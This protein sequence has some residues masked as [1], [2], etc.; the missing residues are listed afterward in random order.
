MVLFHTLKDKVSRILNKVQDTVLPETAEPLLLEPKDAI[1]DH[2]VLVWEE[3]TINSRL[4]NHLA[5]HWFFHSI[6][7]E[8]EENNMVYLGMIT[9]FGGV[10]S[11][12]FKLEDIWCDDYRAAFQIKLDIS[13]I[14]TDSFILNTLIHSLCSWVLSFLGTFFNPFRIGTK[15]S[16]MRFEKKGRIYFDMAPDSDIFS[17]VPLPDRPD[18][19]KGPLLL[20]N[21]KTEQAVLCMDYYA[22]HKPL[23]RF[24]TTDEELPGKSSWLH[25][26]DILAILLLP[27]GVWISFVILHHYLPPRD[28][29]FSFSTY[30]LI[31]LLIIIFSFLVMN[32]PR[33]IYMYFNT[34]KSWQTFFVHN[35]IKIQMR[36]LHRRIYTQ[37]QAIRAEG[38]YADTSYQERI[39]NFL[40]QIRNKRYLAFQLLELDEDR[41]RKQKVKFAIAYIG[42]TFLEWILLMT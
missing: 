25:S 2:Q 23:D 33:Y 24:V 6:T 34:R 35:N 1:Y 19:S 16:T 38:G 20:N 36:K 42:C 39:Q 28:L 9:R 37:Q 4:A 40:I 26:I 18:F 22:F 7:F 3:D 14:E 31:S 41:K 12:Q 8:F 32:I 10:M 21:A 30:F 15:G 11:L 13:S 17:I 27:I 29:T 5:N